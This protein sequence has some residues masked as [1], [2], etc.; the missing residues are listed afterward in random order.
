MA[1]YRNIFTFYLVIEP[2]YKYTFT[3][4]FNGALSS[5]LGQIPEEG[6]FGEVSYLSRINN[7]DTRRD[8][9]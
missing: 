2:I 6:K 4:L 5:K 1:G 9:A 7:I 8:C 3:F